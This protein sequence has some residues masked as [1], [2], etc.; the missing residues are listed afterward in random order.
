MYTFIIALLP[1]AIFGISIY[2][3]HAVRVISV[4]VASAMAFE[5]II[6]KLFKQKVTV[7]DG[8]A[9][10]IG[11]LFALIL[12]PSVPWWLIVIGTFVSILVGKQIFGGTGGNPFNPVLIGWAAIRISWTLPGKKLPR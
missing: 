9:I 7:S 4:A 12:P 5:W 6:Q 10:L 3:M 1:A 2:K 11:L 8:N